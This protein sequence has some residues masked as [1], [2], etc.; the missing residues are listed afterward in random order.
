MRK[1]DLN[2]ILHSF[3]GLLLDL[4]GTFM[5]GQDR[6]GPN[7]D[8]YATYRSVGGAGLAEAELRRAIDSC[9]AELDRIS[10]DVAHHDSFPSVAEALLTFP[11]TCHLSDYERSWVES[12]YAYHEVGQVS[13]AYSTV[14]QE[15][16]RTYRLGL[17]SNIWSRKE[18][19][20]L[21]LKRAGVLQLFSTLVF[22]SDGMSIK[23]SPVLFEQAVTE[24]DLPT[25]EVAMIGDSLRCDVGGAAAAGLASVWINA[26]GEA[27]PIDVPKPTYTI[28]DLQELVARE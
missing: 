23:P 4:N 27:V 24:L 9:F 11:E 3:S 7:E 15:L 26:K 28:H 25:Q 14:L 19:F 2:P 17:V 21:E 6:F 10:K 1:Q 13:M 12:V 16:A 22:S 20:V 18:I 8:Y 5:F